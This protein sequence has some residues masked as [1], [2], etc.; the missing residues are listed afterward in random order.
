MT[1]SMHVDASIC[2]AHGLCVREAP[3]VFDLPEDDDHAVVLIDPIPQQLVAAARRAFAGCPEQ[4]IGEVTAAD[5][6]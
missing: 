3:D 6:A 1:L 5:Q 2:Q 4:A